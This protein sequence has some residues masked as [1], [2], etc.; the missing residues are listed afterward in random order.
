MVKNSSANAGDLGDRSSIPWRRKRQ[1][2]PK[3]LAGKCHTQR[4]LVGYSAQG[5][6]DL[7]TTGGT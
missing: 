6:K 5:H 2:T 1:P 7:D 3:F 4:S